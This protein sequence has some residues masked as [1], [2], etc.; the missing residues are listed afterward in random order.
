MDER[1]RENKTRYIEDTAQ[2]FFNNL[3]NLS[4]ISLDKV[5]LTI[6]WCERV[7]ELLRVEEKKRELSANIRWQKEIK[8]EELPVSIVVIPREEVMT[9][10]VDIARYTKDSISFLIQ[11]NKKSLM[12]KET[13]QVNK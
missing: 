10:S 11:K 7:I 1:E 8:D 4:S 2:I 6:Q 5:A 9:I 12:R 13:L 3:M